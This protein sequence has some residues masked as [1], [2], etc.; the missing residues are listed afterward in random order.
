[1][2]S[3]LTLLTVLSWYAFVRLK[4]KRVRNAVFYVAVSGLLIFTHVYALFVILAQN[5]YVALSETR[6]GIQLRQWI[7]VQAALGVVASPWI[8][9]LLS[10][11][12]NLG[13][14]NAALVT[15]IPKPDGFRSIMKTLSRFIGFP[16]HYPFLQGT[17]DAPLAGATNPWELSWILAALVLA[18]FLFCAVFAVVRF[19]PDEG[20]EI[21]DIQESSQLALLFLSPILAPFIISYILT[22][23]YWT[24]YAIPASIGFVLLAGK[25]ITNINSQWRRRALLGFIVV[26]SLFFAG[27]YYSQSS[28]EDWGGSADCLNSG[29][30]DTDLVI[31]QP[32]WIEP[33]L[34]YYGTGDFTKDRLPPSE[35]MTDQEINTLQ[36]YAEEYDEIWLLRY[37]PGEPP[38]TDDQ[39]FTTLNASYG[40]LSEVHDGAFSTYQFTRN[41]NESDSLS[42]R[43]LSSEVRIW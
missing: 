6:N 21:V 11:V 14:N 9:A 8:I 27:V 3:L 13:G 7:S 30:E 10:R 1:M 37:H 16:V 38:Q 26:S 12:L 42:S 24:R 22:P 33:R 28:V 41:G 19:K 18:A 5:V 35:S 20:Y 2:Y 40:Q 43:C 4:R 25:G 34:D 17:S 39:V 29:A 32:A 36:E 31:Y 23:I 15:W